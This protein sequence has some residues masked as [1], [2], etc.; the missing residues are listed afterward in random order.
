MDGIRAPEESYDALTIEQNERLTSWLEE[1]LENTQ[2]FAKSVHRTTLNHRNRIMLY[3]RALSEVKRRLLITACPAEDTGF[4][5]AADSSNRIRDK[6]RVL[7]TV[8]Y[9][10]EGLDGIEIMAR[11]TKGVMI[12]TGNERIVYGDHGP[13]FEFRRDQNQLGKLSDGSQEE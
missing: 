4:K 11:N 9:F 1:M 3:D 6:V 7:H 2:F 12:A 5:T 13:Y 8:N 10:E